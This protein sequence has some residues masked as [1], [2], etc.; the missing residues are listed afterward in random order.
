MAEIL[1]TQQNLTSK[2]QIGRIF[3]VITYYNDSLA[4]C[5]IISATRFG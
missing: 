2:L 1:A 5:S 4:A 3:S